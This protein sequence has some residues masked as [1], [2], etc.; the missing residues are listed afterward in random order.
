MSHGGA[1]W[2]AIIS[3]ISAIFALWVCVAYLT[4]STAGDATAALIFISL[5]AS[6]IAAAAL[7]AGHDAKPSVYTYTP[8]VAPP[9]AQYTERRIVETETTTTSPGEA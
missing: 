8:V 3:G 4:G 2:A 1:T 5:V 7:Q 9:P 6:W